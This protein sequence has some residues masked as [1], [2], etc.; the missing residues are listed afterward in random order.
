MRWD[1]VATDWLIPVACSMRALS[2]MGKPARHTMSRAPPAS[3][4]HR[5][6]T[7]CRLMPW[8]PSCVSP[9]PQT[10][11]PTQVKPDLSFPDSVVGVA[12]FA[13]GVPASISISL[14]AHQV[15]TWACVCVCVC[16]GGGYTHY[17]VKS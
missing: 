7:P 6:Y 14:A 8:P 16:G 4:A 10:P 1:S 15:G 12:T 2:R 17:E 5:D 13:S 11:T 3:C 9:A